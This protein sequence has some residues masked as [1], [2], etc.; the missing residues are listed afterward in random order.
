MKTRVETDYPRGPSCPFRLTKQRGLWERDCK[1]HAYRQFWA[2]SEV[3]NPWPA[4]QF[5][6]IHVCK[7]IANKVN[8]IIAMPQT[9][10]ERAR[11]FRK[12]LKENSKLPEVYKTKDRERK[13]AERRRPKFQSAAEIAQQRKLNRD[14][15]GSGNIECL[16]RKRERYSKKVKTKV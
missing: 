13:K 5:L 9:G 8:F 16:R 1:K 6:L 7:L 11:K 14:S 10:S 2:C 15:T 4:T 3:Q 12:K